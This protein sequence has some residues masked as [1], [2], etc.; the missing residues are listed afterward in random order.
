MI[1]EV[2]GPKRAAGRDLLQHLLDGAGVVFHPAIH[3]RPVP[4]LFHPMPEQ[5]PTLDRYQC[6][7]V[8]PVLDHLPRSPSDP[9]GESHRIATESSE[10]GKEVGPGNDVDGV[11]LDCS[12]PIDHPA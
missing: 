4:V 9:I 3:R 12:D 7:F 8:R 5:R 6:G 10:E 11:K 1:F 2:T